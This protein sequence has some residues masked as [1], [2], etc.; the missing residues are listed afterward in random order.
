M[1]RQALNGQEDDLFEL[2]GLNFLA[3]NL[4]FK[5]TLFLY[6]CEVKKLMII[7]FLSS[8]VAVSSH[9]LT[10][11]STDSLGVLKADSVVSIG[12]ISSVAANFSIDTSVLEASRHLSLGDLL[13]QSSN[14][15]IRNY[16]RGGKQT[17]SLRGTGSTHTKVIWNGIEINSPLEG[18][19]DL[20]LIPMQFIDNVRVV[21]SD[22]AIGGKIFIDSSPEFG[23]RS[24]LSLSGGYGSFNSWNIALN[25]R[26]S[27]GD[28]QSV[29]KV[30]YGY[31]KNDFEFVNRDIIDPLRPG[32]HP[33]QRNENADYWNFGAIEELHYRIDDRSLVSA[34]V[35][36]GISD[37]NLPQL[38]T[39]EGSRNSHLTNSKDK[40]LRATVNYKRY[41]EKLELSARIKGDLQE[42]RFDQLN[43]IVDGYESVINSNGLSRSL[44]G[45]VGLTFLLKEKGKSAHKLTSLTDIR[46]DQ[47]DSY[48]VVKKQGF[49][50]SRI[51]FSECLG[52]SSV[53]NK[54]WRSEFSLKAGLVGINFYL[55]PLAAV[56][57]EVSKWLLLRGQ[58][59]YNTQHPTL[60]D[61]YFTPGGN[62]DLRPEKGV[63]VELGAEFD[64]LGIKVDLNFYG[65]WIDDW[66]IWLPSHQQ[67][68]SPQN[69]RK[70]RAMGVEL[71]VSKQWRVGSWTFN[72]VG[73]GSFNS[74][75]NQGEKLTENDAAIN[76]QLAYVPLFSGGVFVQ[77]D[78][79]GLYLNYRV[80]GESAKYSTTS[81]NPN[82]L[83]T[84]EPYALNDVA[85]GYGYRFIKGE[86]ICKNI[87]NSQ[88]YGILRRPMAPISVEFRLKVK[89]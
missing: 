38:T 84:I 46:V 13:Q 47:V 7:I 40:N 65:S 23:K 15:N 12:R 55:T 88:Y 27:I 72:V 16:G 52:L 1:S 68:W 11:H 10:A 31:S 79:K 64:V 73:N 60:S 33:M 9:P 44:S 87:F 35:W 45:D 24:G 34:I 51:Q 20:S 76:N 19:V 83:N 56:E 3:T 80:Y 32:W 29:T 53:W 85:L 86:L 41:G 2:E 5:L 71:S 67:Y 26:L 50:K 74:T 62:A 25:G 58:A 21:P 42:S 81:A 4:A 63:S 30:F 70:V 89:I 69:I 49:S 39:Y 57:F 8:F 28:F 37:R 66:I 14:V 18:S 77:A 61:L 22:G 54:H 78:W 6:L 82:R 36:G 43:R 75:V 59:T 48:E 17:V